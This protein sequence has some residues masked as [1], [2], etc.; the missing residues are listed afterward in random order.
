MKRLFGVGLL[1]AAWVLG[2]SLSWAGP[3][4]LTGH[5]PDFHAQDSLG[6]R[7]LL[8]AGLNFVTG[9]TFN[10]G[11]KKF[12]W[13]EGLF[14]SD[15]PSGL[16]G[17]HRIGE[18]GLEAIGLTPGVN[19]DQVDAAGFATANLSN[20]TAI[21]VASSF[22][23]LL[24]QQELNALIAR[25]N[26]IQNFVNAGGGVLALSE[27]FPT[28]DACL[29]DLL[30]G[31]PSLYGFLPVTVSSIPPVA[32]FNVTAAGA[33]APFNLTNGD[34]NDPTHN[35]FGLIGGLT[36]LDLDSGN[37][38]Q[39]TTL[40]GDVRIGGGQFCGVPGTPPCPP[41]GVPEP[42]TLLLLG[43]GFAG[44]VAIAWRRNRAK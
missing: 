11:V 8:T 27:C 2:P 34:I 16:P 23:G 32:P 4:F 9:G 42:G 18:K 12:L 33:A 24:R 30:G 6:A 41:P 13:V 29:A 14:P 36:A 1:V 15:F 40:A 37:P 3:I 21:G 35:S 5:D 10:G 22:G 25:K 28:G 17:G 19:F 38:H 44:F 7:H 39:A 26:D 31:S 20:Y 43:S